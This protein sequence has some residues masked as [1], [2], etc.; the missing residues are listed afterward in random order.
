MVKDG[1]IKAPLYVQ[2]V[3]GVKNAMPVDR[4]TFDFYIETVKRIAPDAEWC[5]AGIGPNQIVAQRVVHRRRRPYPHRARGQ[6]AA[7]QARAGAVER[8]AGAR[9]PSSA[10]KHGRPVATPAEARAILGL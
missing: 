6:S 1:R 7:R 8:R 10:R 5:A 3:M 2:F 9:M 4:P